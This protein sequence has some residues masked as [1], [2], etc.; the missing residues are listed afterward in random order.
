MSGGRFF[1]INS[2]MSEDKEEKKP[3]NEKDYAF[4]DDFTYKHDNPY[5]D[6][7]GLFDE[8]VLRDDEGEGHRGNW[9]KEVFK[10]DHELNVEIGTGYGHFMIDFTQKNP[11]V[12]FVGMD[13]RFKRSYNLARKLEKL[14]HKNFRYLRARGERLGHLFGESEI[15]KL[16]Y[17]FPDPWPKK[18]HNKK[19]LFQKT[20]LDIAHKTIKDGG[21]LLVKTDH[22]GYFEWMLEELESETRFKKQM[23]TFDLKKEHPE[24]FLASF[25]TKFEKIF[26][27]K[28]IK[29]K[30]MVLINQKG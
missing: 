13:H 22:D 9:S 26:L 14:E 30:A 24:H 20:F 19:R 27:E 3:T 5:H 1:C 2:P 15:S 4:K 10:N 18:R 29:I 8:I 6:K 21:E 23:V 17:F 12:N 7:L 28:G 11:M 25:E 16:F